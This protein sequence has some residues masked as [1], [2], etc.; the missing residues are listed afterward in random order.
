M[1][2]HLE[3]RTMKLAMQAPLASRYRE[4]LEGG[5]EFGE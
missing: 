4:P 3:V 5:G 1:K 2:I